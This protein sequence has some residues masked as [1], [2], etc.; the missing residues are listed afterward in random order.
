MSEG[1]QSVPVKDGE[2]A[3]IEQKFTP[4]VVRTSGLP[5]GLP[6]QDY[7]QYLRRDF[8]YACAY[9]TMTESEAEAIRFT[10][11]HYDPQ[12][13]KPEL[14]D[15]Y[16]NLMYACDECNMRKGNACP[17]EE[18]RRDGKRFFRADQDLRGEHFELDGSQV[19]GKTNVGN[20]TT[21]AVDLN[22][23]ALVRLR[24]LRQ[25]LI[26][27]DVYVSEGMRALASFAIDRL[28][29][30]VRAKALSAIKKGLE[31][32]GKV[33]DDMDEALLEMSKSQMLLD[34]KTEE[35]RRANRE[36]IAKLRQMDGLYPA[37]WR[38]RKTSKKKR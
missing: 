18:M 29:P 24:E 35:D 30:E 16:E 2:T 32:A 19:K 5:V 9:C 13:V 11:D 3:V 28:K 23:R 10:I 21:L 26:D 33:Y 37:A 14:K 25:R 22:R 27:D 4:P 17:T 38:G 31:I 20:Y 8:W 12:S 34:E 1:E 6:Y 36:R 15:V 7:K